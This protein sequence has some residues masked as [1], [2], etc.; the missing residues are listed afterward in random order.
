MNET[1]YRNGLRFSCQRCG[2]C[3][4]DE[5][6]YTEVYVDDEDIA[7]MAD[8]LGIYPSQ[9][10]K[11]YVK[12]SEGFTVLRSRKGACIMLSQGRCR[13]HPN[14]PRQCR[15]WPFWP[16]NLSRHV[17]YGEVRK[18]CPGVGKGRRYTVEEIESIL[19]SHS[20]VP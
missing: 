9:F 11:R 18:R 8:H 16:Q 6:E 13:A 1:W 4:Y 10:R 12:K 19:T 5:G 15:T 17:W 20:L 7:R 3:C 14:H 2:Q